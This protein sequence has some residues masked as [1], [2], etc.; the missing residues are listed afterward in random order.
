MKT[1]LFVC[2][3]NICR[4]PMA[5][6]LFQELVKGADFEVIS[7]GIGAMTGQHPSPHSVDAMDEIG[8]D[9]SMLRSK[10]I[11]A[12]MVRRADYIFVMTYGHLDSMLLLFP[13]AAEKTFLLRE[14]ETHLP[15][16]EREVSDPIG[17]SLDTYRYCRDQIREALPGILEHIIGSGQALEQARGGQGRSGALARISIAADHSGVEL[18]QG[19]IQYLAGAGYAGDD[20]GTYT[21]V[22][23]DA[24]DYALRAAQTVSQ[25]EA[26]YA[27]L[28][29]RTGM[30]M[31][32][33]ANKLPGVRAVTVY[34]TDM[35]R[36]ARELLDANVLCL[37]ARDMKVRRAKE[38]LETWLRT[39]YHESSPYDG[40]FD[41]MD[42][43]TR[44]DTDASASSSTR[45]SLQESDPQIFK[46]IQ[47]END[48]Q[49]DNIELIAS[50]NFTSRAVMEAQGSCFTNKYAEG[51]P[52]KRWYGGCEYADGVEQL[53]IDRA[54]EL[55]GAEYANVQPHSGSQANMA[56]YFALIKPG[57]TILT[58]D[59]SH[60]GHLTHGHQ[61]NFS[62]KLFNVVHYGVSPET[63]VLDYDA[64]AKQALEVR[65]RMITA[66]ASAYSRVI[67]W[68]RLRQ[69]ADS[70]GA[71]L[72]V[73]M[74]HI[75]GLV[76]AGVHPT[77]LP[78]AHVVT[79]TTHKTLRGPRA[80]LILS[81]TQEF[82]K[83]IDAQVF[84]GCQGGPLMHVIAA[85][86]VCLAEALRPEFKAYQQQ[87]ANNAK[88]LAEGM[89]HHGFR[90]VSGGTENHLMLVDLQPKGLTGKDVQ[91]L[92]DSVGITVNKNAI[93]FDKQSPF[94]AGGIRL[95]TPAVTTRGMKEDEMFDIASLINKAI[96]GKDDPATLDQVRAAVREMTARFGLPY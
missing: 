37:P 8:L 2:T 21:T 30:A 90:I 22:P 9:I 72:F 24:T 92:L 42:T 57:D 76:A 13:Y 51:Y 12:E 44:P 29:C 48:R 54:K 85:K 56:V 67:D 61:A 31:A 70:V 47:E 78:H 59:L 62:G 91:I 69:I 93:P 89:K 38:I 49:R 27:I 60:G 66:G 63:E 6:G 3:G 16:M 79:T 95:G 28:I 35:A 18:K 36:Q 88:A 34:S 77:P 55:F 83:A 7:A 68:A 26:D 45:P 73:D 71:Y 46:L 11:T 58:M 74:A 80:G 64:I 4:S 17:Q 15:A 14:F 41:T 20:F 65:P 32:V 10:P 43:H 33:A 84:P 50:E 40:L 5:H 23:V 1:V 75:A 86:A 25:G 39:A 94:K 87:V 81:A 19:L 53:A 52:G 82:A 96:I